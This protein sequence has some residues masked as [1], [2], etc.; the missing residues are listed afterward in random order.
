[1][2]IVDTIEELKKAIDSGDTYIVIRGDLAKDVKNSYELKKISKDNLPSYSI[3]EKFFSVHIKDEMY[4]IFMSPDHIKYAGY[5]I[6]KSLIEKYEIIEYKISSRNGIEELK[7]H[8]R[9]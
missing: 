2:A 7:L 9:K 4:G 1:M 6:L 8:K 5:S 3:F